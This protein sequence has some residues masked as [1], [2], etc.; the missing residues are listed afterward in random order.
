MQ[1]VDLFITNGRNVVSEA[2]VVGPSLEEMEYQNLG[3]PVVPNYNFIT[4]VNSYLLIYYGIDIYPVTQSK[5][6]RV[7]LNSIKAVISSLLIL[8]ISENVYL[9]ILRGDRKFE[10]AA[11]SGVSRWLCLFM[12]IAFWYKIPAI[13]RCHQMLTSLSSNTD[14]K[15]DHE[16]LKQ[17]SI[18]FVIG[19]W[20]FKLVYIT[21]SIIAD[22][23]RDKTEAFIFRSIDV[24]N[25]L[26]Y[27]EVLSLFIIV[28][29]NAVWGHWFFTTIF[30]YNYFII[31]YGMISEHYLNNLTFIT[32]NEKNRSKINLR[33]LIHRLMMHKKIRVGKNLTHLDIRVKRQ[34]S[35]RIFMEKYLENLII[36][37]NKQYDCDPINRKRKTI[38]E[39]DT[40]KSCLESGFR[41]FPFV[42]FSMVFVYTYLYIASPLHE[43]Y[44]LKWFFFSSCIIATISP[45][46]IIDYINRRNLSK[47]QEIRKEFFNNQRL[48]PHLENLNRLLDDIKSCI[49]LEMTGWGMFELKRQLIASFLVTQAS[50]SVVLKGLIGGYDQPTNTTSI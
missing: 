5:V 31:T 25:T 19:T 47:I 29:E 12:F 43:L 7:L 20:I 44:N 16:D 40:Y 42:S 1:S 9:Q 45:I 18:R 14:V 26:P 27:H 22:R 32:L 34:N 17:L 37:N 6:K 21:A 38:Y 36:R 50:F 4:P 41:F 13:Q 30:I 48:F 2:I 24:L 3:D 33:I 10:L 23:L 8:M 35:R 49:L 11:H 15:L 28:I 39:I 46:F